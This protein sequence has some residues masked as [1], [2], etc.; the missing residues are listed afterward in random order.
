[1]RD[2]LL[3]LRLA[4]GFLQA[5]LKDSQMQKKPQKIKELILP[6]AEEMYEVILSTEPRERGKN[7]LEAFTQDKYH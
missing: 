7:E 3:L 6:A 5:G 1:M 2:R 4:D